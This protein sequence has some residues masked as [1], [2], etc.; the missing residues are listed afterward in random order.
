[1]KPYFEILHIDPACSARTGILNT[2]HGM[3]HTPVFMPV[4]T[5]GTVKALTPKDLID[6]EVEIIL[7]NTY[8][9][10]LRPGNQII[11]E[12]GGLHHFISWNKPIL[13]DSGG[14]QVFSL[15][16][17]IKISEEGVQFKSHLDGSSHFFSPERVME[18]Q[19]DFGSDIIMTFDECT[20]YPATYEYANHSQSRTTR[21]ATRCKNHFDTLLP[22]SSFTPQ[23]LFGIV[24]GS[25][26][27][28]LRRISAESICALDFSGNAIGGL[29]VGEPKELM[30]Q[31]IE[32]TTPLLPTD[33]PRYL[34]GVGMP[35]DIIEAVKNGIDMFDCVVPTRYGRNGTVFTFEGK[36]NIRNAKYKQNH[37]PID[38]HC[39]CY[40]CSNFSTA[41]LRHLIHA[42]EILGAHLLT[43]HNIHFFMSFMNQLRQS[44]HEN[45]FMNWSK[46]FLSHYLSA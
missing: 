44:I 42:G 29:S 43:L 4:G 28:E 9:M 26:F 37:L 6:N 45:R 13:T 16:D 22:H 35:D 31:M 14:Y 33:K 46:C 36:K 11:R 30:I 32:V 41:Y 27:A 40:A 19:T 12:F 1:M 34:M 21:W 18:I 17:L 39:Q 38:T 3:I 20:P 25:T 7:N 8:H 10:Y 24:Q 5:Q 2:T 23:L 15:L